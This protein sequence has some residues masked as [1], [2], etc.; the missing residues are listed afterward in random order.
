MPT[1]FELFGIR[2][3]FYAG[4]H[5]PIHIHLENADGNA[6]VYLEPEPKVDYNH[7]IKAKDIK[8]ALK[9]IET[10]KDEIIESWSK[11]H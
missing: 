5:E 9:M 4:D 2:Y 6:K 8:K 3:F 7:G 10:Y 11:H 1:V